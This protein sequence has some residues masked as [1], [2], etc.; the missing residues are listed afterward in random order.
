MESLVLLEYNMLGIDMEVLSL[1]VHKRTR[2]RALSVCLG[3]DGHV[4]SN[5]GLF[6]CCLVFYVPF[7]ME[8]G[9]GMIDTAGFFSR[10]SG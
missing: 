9:E 4:L 2:C 3:T 1:A 8:D 5:V 7:P 6:V 10:L